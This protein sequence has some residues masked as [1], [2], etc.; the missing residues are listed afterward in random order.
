M[1]RVE[2]SGDITSPDARVLQSGVRHFTTTVV[3]AETPPTAP[4]WPG[5]GAAEE[6]AVVD[7]YH[8]DGASVC[9]R[10]AFVTT[11]D[12]RMHPLGK[13]ARYVPPVRAGDPVF[14]RFVV[15]SLL[16][17]GLARVAV[18]TVIENRYVPV[19]APRS[20]RRIDLYEAGSDA[21]LGARYDSLELTVTPA[22]LSLEDADAAN[23]FVAATAEGRMVAQMHD[24]KGVV[25][26]YVDLLTGVPVARS[27]VAESNQR[28]IPQP[29]AIAL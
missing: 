12:L 5:L 2:I 20:I 22:Q 3:M 16:L 13:R 24:V 29:A 17:D 26:G 15:P 4:V 9:L 8:V 19:A 23:R 27:A 1:V 7:P 14:G 18:A 21:V 10:G 25:L 6:I 11:R 28:A